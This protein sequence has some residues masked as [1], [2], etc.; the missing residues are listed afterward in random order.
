[1][2]ILF[3]REFVCIL[4]VYPFVYSLYTCLYTLRIPVVYPF[5]YSL[6]IVAPTWLRRGHTQG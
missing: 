2:A 1:M 6:A 5:V 4:F 3:C